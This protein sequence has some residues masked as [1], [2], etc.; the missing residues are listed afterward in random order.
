M[1]PVTL[2]NKQRSAESTV[3]AVLT[4]ISCL[5]KADYSIGDCN[6]NFFQLLE[7]RVGD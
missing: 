3:I 7:H 1:K 4:K 5:M 2:S 6:P